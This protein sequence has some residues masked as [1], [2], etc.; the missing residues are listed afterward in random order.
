MTP[1]HRCPQPAI[2]LFALFALA[3]LVPTGP[4]AASADDRPDPT[5][6]TPETVADL[7]RLEKQV[8]ELVARALPSTVSVWI[9]S[10]WG[11]GVVISEDGK[12]LT[13]GHVAGQTGRFVRVRFPDGTE[14][15]ARTHGSHRDTDMGLI[16]IDSPKK[17]AHLEIGDSD[18][19]AI[20]DWCVAIGYPD[21][22][23][24]GRHSLVRLGRVIDLE[25]MFIRTDCPLVGG[26]SGGP[27]LDLQGARDRHPQSYPAPPDPELPRAHQRVRRQLG[28]AHRLAGPGSGAR[29]RGQGTPRAVV[30]AGWS[31]C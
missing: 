4:W 17:F 29:P 24:R 25:K 21:A 31:A 26:D 20:G 9:G 2:V 22:Q 3:T 14:Y 1:R 16:Q 27:L 30:A 12:I 10:A 8:T 15:N 28:S 19:V 5:A 6:H 13:A 11:T 7:E 18:E 23:R